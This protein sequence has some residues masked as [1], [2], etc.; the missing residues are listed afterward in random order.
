MSRTRLAGQSVVA[1]A[2]VLAG[3]SGGSTPTVVQGD[4]SRL[5]DV[6]ASFGPEFTV[7]TVAPTGIDPV[8][9]THLTLPTT[10]YV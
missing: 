8:S 4:I 6:R 7:N 5:V 9:Y 10:P 2:L 3:C 1:C